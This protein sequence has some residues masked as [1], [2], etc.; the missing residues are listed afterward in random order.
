[1]TRKWHTTLEASGTEWPALRNHIQCLAH[2]IQ[3]ALGAFMSSIG[4]K[5]C[6]KSWETHEHNQQFGE[7]DS[8]DIGKSRRPRKE[9]NPRINKVS[10]MR[11]SLAK[12]IEKVH[13]SRYFE[14]PETDL[15]I[16]VHACSIDDADS[17]LSKRVH[18][19]SQRQYTNRSTTNFG[20]QGTV[21]CIPG[22][23]WP[24]LS[25]TWIHSCVARYSTIR[26]LPATLHNTSWI[27]H[28]PVCHGHFKASPIVEPLDV[29]KAYGYASSCH[30]G[31][32]WHVRS[33]G[34]HYV[35]SS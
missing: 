13:I 7:N 23:A 4:V 25:S 17:G 15:Y 5:G 9:G 16:A 28:H 12:I 26:R 20:C 32:H 21:E 29:E 11:Q 30:H 33:Y 2:V 10:A 35:T 6:T 19:L 3:H 31:L 34:W 18:W 8:I 24:S 1:M 14:Y 22:V 27:D